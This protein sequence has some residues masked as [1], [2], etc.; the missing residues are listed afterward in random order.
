MAFLF[1][2]HPLFRVLFERQPK[3]TPLGAFALEAS[4][5]ELAWVTM[6]TGQRVD[7]LRSRALTLVYGA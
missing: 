6:S 5:A 2:A 1:R 7:L 3:V 4:D